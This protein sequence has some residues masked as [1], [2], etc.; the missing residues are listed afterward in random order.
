MEPT[1]AT[2]LVLP[3]AKCRVVQRTNNSMRLDLGKGIG[4]VVELPDF[5]DVKEGD[6]LTL[7]TEVLYAKPSGTPVQ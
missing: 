3:L 4:M 2:R 5:A 1:K 7:Y 6:I